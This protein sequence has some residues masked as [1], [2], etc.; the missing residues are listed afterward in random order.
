MAG[1][2][3]Q[4]LA[5]AH[6]HAALPALHLPQ[7]APVDAHGQRSALVPHPQELLLARLLP[8]PLLVLPLRG[9]QARGDRGGVG[10]RGVPGRGPWGG[11]GRT[12]EVPGGEGEG[13]PGEPEG[14]QE[15]GDGGQ[16]DAEEARGEA[17]RPHGVGDAGAVGGLGG[18]GHA[19]EVGGGP[20]VRLRPTAKGQRGKVSQTLD[21]KSLDPQC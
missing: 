12:G 16:V 20:R 2:E 3:E 5:K 13:G 1:D 15:H 4:E 10:D 14:V 17:A 7:V 18:E 19:E 21:Q 11:P 6:A 9:Q 8:R